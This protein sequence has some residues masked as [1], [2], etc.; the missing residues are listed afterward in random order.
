MAAGDQFYHASLPVKRQFIRRKAGECGL[1]VTSE[2]RQDPNSFHG[3]GRA[4]DVSG[5]PNGMSEFFR[6]F[7][8]LAANGKGVRE[9]F[10][11]PEGAYDNGQRIP[12]IGDHSDHVHIAFD[13][14][15]G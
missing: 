14:P 8:P 6:A 12:A 4:I 9:L 2:N 11:D 10:Y 1:T 13:P 15:P 7:A 5:S 3:R